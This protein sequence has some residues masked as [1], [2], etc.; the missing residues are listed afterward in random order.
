L[1]RLDK[2]GKKRQG[3]KGTNPAQQGGRLNL[4][5]Q[6]I[7]R[8]RENELRGARGDLAVSSEPQNPGITSGYPLLPKTGRGWL[9][10]FK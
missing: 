9:K 10:S 6:T 2:G 8:K 5:K 7:R 1:K 4:E 3:G